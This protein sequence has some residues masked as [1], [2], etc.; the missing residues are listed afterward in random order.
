MN[1]TLQLNQVSLRILFIDPEIQIF[2]LQ[3]CIDRWEVF[4]KG[5]DCYP[6]EK[7]WWHFVVT[8]PDLYPTQPPDIRCISIPYHLNISLEGK[9][10]F[11]QLEKSYHPLIHVVEYLEDLKELFILPNLK[12]ANQLEKLDLFINNP[13][14]YEKLARQSARDNARENYVDFLKGVHV[15]DSVDDDFMQSLIDKKEYYPYDYDMRPTRNHNKRKIIFS[16]DVFYDRNELIQLVAG[17]VLT[18]KPEDPL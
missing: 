15:N 2:P 5:P 17:S 13:K 11:D 9:I 7:K 18:E 6:Y 12:S 10:C 1:Y 3:S 4:I 14:K 8:F 16:S